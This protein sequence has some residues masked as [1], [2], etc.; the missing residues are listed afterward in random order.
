M[1]EN[2]N[3]ERVEGMQVI[4]PREL[5]PY[6]IRAKKQ[7]Q[8]F[9]LGQNEIYL[10]DGKKISFP[11]PNNIALNLNISAKEYDIAIK[12]FEKKIRP[13]LMQSKS[14][15]FKKEEVSE[16]YDYFEHLQVSLLFNYTAVEAFSNV[17][18]PEEYQLEK[19]NNKKVKEIW[20]K[21]NIERWLSTSEKIGDIVPKILDVPSPKNESFWNDFKEL[22]KIRDEIVHQ[23]TTTNET[24]VRSRFL[25]EFFKGEIFS[26]IRSGYLVINYFC[27]K[28]K[29]AH[30][31][32]P[33]GIGHPKIEPFEIDDFEN[34]FAEIDEDKT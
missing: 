31:Y 9:V 32:F 28:S 4:D 25:K 5:R 12:M 29:Q 33:V 16:L 11:P 26:I 14:I 34:Y 7:N 18:I 27:T 2:T 6:V 21:E 22:E 23:K 19:L 30:I 8:V 15:D 20:V 10:L 13:L 24:N 17:A 1:E 3:T